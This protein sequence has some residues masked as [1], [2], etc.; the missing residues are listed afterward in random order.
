MNAVAILI[1]IAVV[2]CL[3][4]AAYRFCRA[5]RRRGHVRLRTGRLLYRRR[6]QRAILQARELA[7]AAIAGHADT[8]AHLGAGVILEPAEQAWGRAAARLAVRASQSTWAAYGQASWF[9]HRTRNV[10][11]ETSTERWEDR[12]NIDWLITSQRAS[13]GSPPATN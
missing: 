11:R 7:R 4:R 3:A 9:G 12:G 13:D 8:A 1:L 6:R 2:W 10:T 5:H